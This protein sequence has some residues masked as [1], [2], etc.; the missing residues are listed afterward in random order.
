MTPDISDSIRNLNHIRKEIGVLNRSIISQVNQEVC[1]QDEIKLLY[2]KNQ[3]L[4]YRALE[5]VFEIEKVDPTSKIEK[6]YYNLLFV[7]LEKVLRTIKYH[8]RAT[9]HFWRNSRDSELV[10]NILNEYISSY[11][12]TLVALRSIKTHSL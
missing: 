9:Y 2:K 10:G 1:S 4:F 5:A 6:E 7:Y 8:S 12:A 3:S 11:D